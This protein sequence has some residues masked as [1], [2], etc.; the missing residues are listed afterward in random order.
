M[1][2]GKKITLFWWS[3][4]FLMNK[5]K[6]NYG[7]LLGR[8]LVEKISGKEVVFKHPKIKH[9]FDTNKVLFS[10]GSILSNANKR[11]VIWGSGIISKN[12]A[13]KNA[14]F[15]AVRG[16]QTRAFLLEKGYEV[17]EVYGDPALLLPD[18]YNP[19][20]TPIYRLG[21]VPHYSDYEEVKEWFKDDKSVLVIDLM[22]NSVELTTD[23]FLKCERIVSS[24]LHGIILSHAYN[25]PAVWQKISNKLFGDNIKFQDYFESVDLPNYKSEILQ[26][27]PTLKLLEDLFDRHPSL[28]KKEKIESLKKGLLEV[29]PC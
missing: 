29:F 12:I 17:P 9:F 19:K 15:L 24:S 6:E 25:I 13:V 16:P 22:T 10:I 23:C 5:L 18:Y 2:S 11:C 27:K 8:Y 3:E 14:T 28:P 20:I 4:V 1:F 26:N 21:I 7:D